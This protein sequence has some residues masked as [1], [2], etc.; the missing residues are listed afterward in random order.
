[1]SNLSRDTRE[2]LEWE[3][4]DEYTDCERKRI[5]GRIELQQAQLS[6]KQV[7]AKTLKSTALK[8]D[9]KSVEKALEIAGVDEATAKA[10]KAEYAKAQL[11][12][13]FGIEV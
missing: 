12:E 13:L 6:V 4:L 7:R 8:Q 3:L 10:K 1:M 5:K 9:L 11:K 2:Q